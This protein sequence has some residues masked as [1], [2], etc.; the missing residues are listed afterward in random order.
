M[1]LVGTRALVLEELESCG[2]CCYSVIYVGGLLGLLL[3]ER[4]RYGY[5]EVLEVVVGGAE[6]G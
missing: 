5:Y 3:V 2:S 6:V 1:H 4:L